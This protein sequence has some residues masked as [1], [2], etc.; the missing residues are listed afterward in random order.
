MTTC[1]QAAFDGNNI[2]FVAVPENRK[3]SS[4]TATLGGSKGLAFDLATDTLT[5]DQTAIATTAELD[6]D[7]PTAV[8]LGP[9]ANIYFGF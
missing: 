6:G 3:G 8:T 7:R 2:V 1:A 5:P 4:G 9:D